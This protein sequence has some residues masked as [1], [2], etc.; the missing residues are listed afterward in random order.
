VEVDHELLHVQ[1][2][3]MSEVSALP[4]VPVLSAGEM[5]EPSPRGGFALA[6]RRFFRDES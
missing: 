3:Q 4:A 1:M 6:A 5:S 2:S